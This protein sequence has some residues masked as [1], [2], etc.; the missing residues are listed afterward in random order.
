MDKKNFV[1]IKDENELRFNKVIM[2][3]SANDVIGV[4]KKE[5]LEGFKGKLMEFVI[6]VSDVFD[7]FS[8]EFDEKMDE[9]V[10]TRL[11]YLYDKLI[12]LLE[13]QRSKENKGVNNS[14]KLKPMGSVD[15]TSLFGDY[16]KMKEFKL[17]DYNDISKT[18]KNRRGS[19]SILF[20]IS[21]S[22]VVFMLILLIKIINI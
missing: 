2:Y 19:L 3:N 5:E 9:I 4:Y 18:S 17:E 10:G 22:L 15:K 6:R 1:Q 16:S 20:V 8:Y 7:E 12:V 11:V 14:V 13:K 21:I